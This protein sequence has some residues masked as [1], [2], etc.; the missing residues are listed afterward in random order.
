MR[1]TNWVLSSQHQF[2]IQLVILLRGAAWRRKTSCPLGTLS[3]TGSGVG[4]GMSGYSEGTTGRGPAQSASRHA[5]TFPRSRSEATRPHPP[6]GRVGYS[7]PRGTT[8]SASQ[9]AT[10][11]GRS[12][13]RNTACRSVDTGTMRRDPRPG[14]PARGC[15]SARYRV[16]L[17]GPEAFVDRP[18]ASQDLS[19]W[20][21]IGPST[22]SRHCPS[23]TLI[24]LRTDRMRTPLVGDTLAGVAA[25]GGF[26][27]VA[28]P[29]V[30]RDALAVDRP[31]HDL[32][33]AVAPV[34]LTGHNRFSVGPPVDVG[35][36]VPNER[37][38]KGG[39]HGKQPAKAD[40]VRS[41]LSSRTQLSANPLG[42]LNLNSIFGLNTP[43]SRGI[44]E[45]TQLLANRA[46][47][48]ELTPCPPLTGTAFLF[49]TSTSWSPSTPAVLITPRANAPFP[50]ACTTGETHRRS[51]VE[52]PQAA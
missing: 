38:A 19:G 6:C 40:S 37:L 31:N 41:R 20:P 8:D 1:Y 44:T 23:A 46:S 21:P 50:A 32:L 28:L 4:V 18:L 16:F 12:R 51:A 47:K 9:S 5:G 27:I 36:T 24:G 34:G 30:N 11:D 48:P 2:D 26:V 13:R 7:R 29:N 22:Q 43:R 17:S 14:D 33:A 42:S 45:G 10:L 35:S 52:L 39:A 25:R 3:S 49:A 15:A